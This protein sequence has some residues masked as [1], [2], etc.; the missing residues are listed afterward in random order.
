MATQLG[1]TP[2][3]AFQICL[4]TWLA[5]SLLADGLAFAGQVREP[6]VSL[7]VNLLYWKLDDI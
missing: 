6:C 2:M 4:Q 3:A 5:Y 1:S 7:V